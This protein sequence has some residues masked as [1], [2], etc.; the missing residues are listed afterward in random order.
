M[1]DEWDQSLLIMMF[2]LLLFLSF[3]LFVHCF[4][5]FFVG[6][7]RA[8]ADFRLFVL[9][10]LFK[11]FLHNFLYSFV[12]AYLVS[13]ADHS[14]RIYVIAFLSG[15]ISTIFRVFLRFC[16]GGFVL[17]VRWFYVVVSVALRLINT[18]HHVLVDVAHNR[19][20][21][22]IFQVFEWLLFW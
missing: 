12:M 17:S 14:L 11:F 21:F 3:F 13:Y 7:S 16:S 2:S 8:W 18:L 10:K 1:A 6:F 22:M 4:W 9:M 20:W 19:S 15:F 5:F